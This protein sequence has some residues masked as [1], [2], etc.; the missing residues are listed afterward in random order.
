MTNYLIGDEVAQVG[1][2]PTPGTGSELVRYDYPWALRIGSP[3]NGS[4]TPVL[5]DTQALVPKPGR[6]LLTAI[7]GQWKWRTS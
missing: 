5:V 4:G 6:A 7:G 1:G 2:T 3:T